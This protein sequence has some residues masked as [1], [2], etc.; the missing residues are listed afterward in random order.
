MLSHNILYTVMYMFI[1]LNKK[2][3]PLIILSFSI[4]FATILSLRTI[5]TFSHTSPYTVVLDAGHGEPDGGAVGIGGTIEKDINLKITLKL[6]EVLENR[7]VRVILTRSDDNSICDKSATTLHEKKVSDMKKRRDIINNSGADLFISIHMN[8]FS[9]AKSN[10]LHVFY[11]RNHPES[12]PL[13]SL[14]Q[15]S[16]AQLTGAKTHAVKTAS[17]SLYLMKNPTPPSILVEC[18][19]ISNPQEEKLLNTDE[20]QSKIAFSIADAIIKAKNM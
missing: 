16:I 6:Q 13:A 10:G 15:D 5:P 17:D 11:A 19:F 3:V 18:G 14:I 7:G 2:S 20:Y 8:S 1:K 9:N 4:V 12:E